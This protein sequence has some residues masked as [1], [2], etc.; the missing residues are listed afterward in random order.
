VDDLI[1]SKR[2]NKKDGLFMIENI[3]VSGDFS[4]SL[5]AADLDMKSMNDLDRVKFIIYIE[6]YFPPKGNN[7]WRK[8]YAHLWLIDIKLDYSAVYTYKDLSLS[9]I[10]YLYIRGHDEKNA[11]LIECSVV[12]ELLVDMW[13]A[14]FRGD[15][16]QLYDLSTK[17][18]NCLYRL[19]M[20]KNEDFI[21]I[22]K[23]V[24]KGSEALNNTAP[25]NP[26]QRD[27]AISLGLQYNQKKFLASNL[28]GNGFKVNKSETAR[29]VCKKLD[30]AFTTVRDYYKTVDFL[31]LMGIN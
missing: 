7:M 4:S 6:D 11:Y 12:I 14:K 15:I 22:G 18:H 26:S 10:R 5:R 21:M 3:R 28:K 29:V 17:S 2:K 8:M 24:K 31:T 25:R 13:Y 19:A 27:E 20:L 1:Q 23:A 30:C 9:I 16:E